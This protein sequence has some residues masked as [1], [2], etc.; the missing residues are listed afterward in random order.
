M[1]TFRFA[2]L[3]SSPATS[4]PI[5]PHLFKSLL[6]VVMDLAEQIRLLTRPE[7]AAPVAA[8]TLFRQP[9][10]LALAN[11]LPQATLT[12]VV[13]VLRSPVARLYQSAITATGMQ[14]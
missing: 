4:K 9:L 3:R 10:Q 12:P 8:T 1:R 5:V 7:K 2:P 14:T 11:H 6:K 13:P